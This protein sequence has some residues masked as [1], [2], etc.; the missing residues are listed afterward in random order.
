M[1][2]KGS[3]GRRTGS[4]RKPLGAYEREITGNAGKRGQ[5]HTLPG[6]PSPPPPAP[7]DEFDAPDDLT[8]EQ[9]QVWLELAPHAFAERT[10]TRA[11]ALSFRLL[12]RNVALELALSR[13]DADRGGPNHR[14]IIQRI[15]AELLRFNLSPCGKALY[16]KAPREQGPVNP[17]AR[18]LERKR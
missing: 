7:V 5:L 4:G 1:G 16:D 14:G 15:D 11:T 3:G 8:L 2:G 17:L 6:A 13:S 12:C 10:L 9:R 18:F